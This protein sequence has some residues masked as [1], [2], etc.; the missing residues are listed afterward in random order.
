MSRFAAAASLPATLLALALLGALPSSSIAQTPGQAPAPAG[1]LPAAKAEELTEEEKAE[2]DGRKA[3]KVAICGAM[4]N[5][6]ATE[7]IS[8]NVLKTWRKEHLD[9]M[10]GRAGVSWPW[11][12]I[13]CTAPIKLKRDMLVNALGEAKYEAAL[14]KHEV[15]CEVERKEGNADIRF[16]FSPKVTFEKGKAVKATLNWGKIEAPTLVKGAMWT[17]TATDNTFNVLQGTIVEDINDFVTAKC[18]EVKDE[19]Q[20]K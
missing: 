18:D 16:E 7:D 6:K 14:D 11:G 17:A 20:A 8:C 5:R 15:H 10:V 9:K 12:R 3:C 4:R 1:Q 2:R 19:W 13:K